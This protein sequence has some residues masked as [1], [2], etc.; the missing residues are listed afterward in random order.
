MSSAMV[1][2]RLISM[3]GMN[4]QTFSFPG[5]AVG[6]RMFTGWSWPWRVATGVTALVVGVPLLAIL[7]IGLIIGALTLTLIGSLLSL[8]RTILLIPMTWTAPAPQ[9]GQPTDDGRRN[10]RVL[11]PRA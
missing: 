9:A 1:D 6:Q 10:V 3:I 7:V 5:S 2:P 8:I 11:E 4:S